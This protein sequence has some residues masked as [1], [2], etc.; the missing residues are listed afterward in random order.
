MP[1]NDRVSLDMQA[2]FSER[3]EEKFDL[4]RDVWLDWKLKT[5]SARC[6]II[7]KNK[8]SFKGQMSKVYLNLFIPCILKYFASAIQLLST[9]TGQCHIQSKSASVPSTLTGFSI[10][11]VESVSGSWPEI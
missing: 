1:T 11:L 6:T 10:C 9:L 7:A 5:E 8:H 3:N 2:G 4:Y